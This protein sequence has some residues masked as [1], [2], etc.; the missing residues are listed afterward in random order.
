MPGFG[1]I[2]PEFTRSGVCKGFRANTTNDT[3]TGG[4][5]M[6]ITTADG[7]MRSHGGWAATAATITG[8]TFALRGRDMAPAGITAAWPITVS[9]EGRSLS[10]GHAWLGYARR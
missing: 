8:L 3:G 9:I 7:G 4:A 6:C 10:R 2:R 5:V 1:S